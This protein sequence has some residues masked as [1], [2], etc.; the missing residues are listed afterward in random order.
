MRTLLFYDLPTLT[1]NDLKNYRKFTKC[2]KKLGFYMIQES[3]YV[4]MSLDPQSMESAV[5]KVK[6]QLPPN[7]NVLLLNITEKQF[8]SMQ[9]LIGDVSTD[10]IT[11]DSR[12]VHL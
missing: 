1:S 3:V 9:I 8:S 7:G 4:R 11:T 12:T 6:L 5:A 10:V 2:I